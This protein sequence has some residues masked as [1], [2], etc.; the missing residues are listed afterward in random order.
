MKGINPEL[1]E[2]KNPAFIDK[3]R[4]EYQVKYSQHCTTLKKMTTP[5]IC[6]TVV[7]NVPIQNKTVDANFNLSNLQFDRKLRMIRAD[8]FSLYS[9]S[10]NHDIIQDS[11][12][13]QILKKSLMKFLE[14]EQNFRVNQMGIF[15]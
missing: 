12:L 14:S 5:L 13:S 9:A 6:G 11:D 2:I 10:M 4:K 7:Q 3:L 15:N 8:I 1:V